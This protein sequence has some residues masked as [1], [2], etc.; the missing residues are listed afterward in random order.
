MSIQSNLKAMIPK[1]IQDTIY[2]RLFG[3]VKVPL[4][5]FVSP[6]VIEMS[7]TKCEIKIPLNRKTKNHLNSMY[8]GVLCTGAGI[9]GGLI[10]M[11]EIQKSKKVL[12]NH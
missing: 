6:K 4:I 11:N 7:D 12:L 10:A 2:V 5:F 1:S 9:S 3:L 8:F